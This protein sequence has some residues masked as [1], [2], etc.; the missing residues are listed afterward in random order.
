ML[1]AVLLRDHLKPLLGHL[2]VE[3]GLRDNTLLAY[4]SDLSIFFDFLEAT[5]D[6]TLAELSLP[7]LGQWLQ[8]LTRRGL[9]E[10]SLARHL[11]ALRALTRF[12]VEE[13]QLESDPSAHLRGSLKPR[14][15]PRPLTV[16]DLLNLMAAPDCTRPRGLRDRAMLSLMYASGLRVS[17]LRHLACADLDLARGLLAALGK[18]G[19]RRL[20]PMGEVALQHVE[21]F[22]AEPRCRPTSSPLLFHNRRGKAFSRQMVWK[23]VGRYARR[24]GIADHVHP[25]RLRHSFATHLLAGGADLRSVQALLGH[26]NIS[27][28][29]IYTHVS[30]DAVRQQYDISH[31]RARRD[32]GKPSNLW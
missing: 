14:R 28:T 13:R 24:V 31:P 17:E 5:T 8:H 7:L 12:L 3:R 29:E 15:L 16:E 1:G 6:G 30:D 9:S 18:G 2:R 21:Q 11:S 26:A 4:E 32:D 20:V 23:M 10:R 22:L 27:T 19:K 25:H